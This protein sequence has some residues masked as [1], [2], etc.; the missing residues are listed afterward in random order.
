VV[1]EH[2][3]LERHSVAPEEELRPLSATPA[4]P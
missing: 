2:G 3:V 4:V 1:G